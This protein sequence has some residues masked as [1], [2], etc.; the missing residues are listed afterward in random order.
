[1]ATVTAEST[2]DEL[3]AVEHFL[4]GVLDVTGAHLAELRGP[5]VQDPGGTGS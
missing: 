4:R 5:T 2:D 3:A 1:M